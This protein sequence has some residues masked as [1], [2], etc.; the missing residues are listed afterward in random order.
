MEKIKEFIGMIAWRVYLWSRN[1]TEDQISDAPCGGFLTVI[2]A[3]VAGVICWETF[4]RVWKKFKRK[5]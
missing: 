3:M 2:L 1:W 5:P 4:K